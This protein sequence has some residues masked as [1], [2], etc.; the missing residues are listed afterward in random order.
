MS[1][2]KKIVWLFKTK[3]KVR[4]EYSSSTIWNY[5]ILENLGY[6]VVY[7]P[8]ED[9]NTDEFYQLVKDYKPDFV[10][11]MG[12]GNVHTE[13]IK[14]REFTKFYI[15]Q[16][17]DDYQYEVNAKF[18]IPFVDGVISYA[19]KYDETYKKDGLD[20]NKFIKIN[21]GFNPNTMMYDGEKTSDIFLSHGGGL[22]GN[23]VNKINEFKNKGID[24]SVIN[25]CFYKEL[26]QVWN[27]SKFSLTFTQNAMMTGQQVKGRVVEIPHF[28]VMVSEYFPGL[29]NYYD[30]EKE[31]ILFDSVEEAIEKINYYN[32][33]DREYNKILKAGQDRVW[34]TNTHYHSWNN[35]LHQIDEDYVKKDIGKLL[36][37]KHG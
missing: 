7:H 28:C 9:Y 24:V 8:Y 4:D 12:Y 2:K 26:K 15:V 11:H 5:G 37:E 33:N 6:D 31:I 27:N 13:L 34:N 35:V 30:L 17:D 25:N 23:R 22:H 3:R 21:W 32:K 14:L 20:E 10:F 29:E 19:A 36:K 16:A 1:D 18:W